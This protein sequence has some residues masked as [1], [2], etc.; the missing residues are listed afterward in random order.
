MT[1]PT[2]TP[3]DKRFLEAVRDHFGE[4]PFSS[5]VLVAC[6]P[7]DL[8]PD[9]IVHGMFQAPHLR[10]DPVRMFGGWLPR[11]VGWE[12]RGLVL[13]K[14]SRK[15]NTQRW[16]FGTPPGKIPANRTMALEPNGRWYW[17]DLG[18]WPD[19]VVK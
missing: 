3:T 15:D 2:M 4:R 14:L 17:Q 10:K 19:E 9:Q 7:S 1:L 16:L 5:G 11:R 6:I 8:Y 12:Y 18:L 13:Q